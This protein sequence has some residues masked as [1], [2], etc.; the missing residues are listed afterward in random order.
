[1]SLLYGAGLRISEAVRLRVKDIDFETS[2]ITVRDGKGGKDRTT[3][4]PET[5]RGMRQSRI[6]SI[7][8][9]WKRQE[10]HYAFPVT[11]PFALSRKYPNA[12][13]SFVWQWLFASQGLRRRFQPSGLRPLLAT[14]PPRPT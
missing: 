10:G 1:M 2:V 5:L 11:L 6:H 8:E 4:L 3:L 13:T 12:G 9:Q 14:L 7:H